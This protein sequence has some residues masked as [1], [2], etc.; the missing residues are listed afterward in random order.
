MQSTSTQKLILLILCWNTIFRA[1]VKHT[2]ALR[3]RQRAG[4]Y[5]KD[6]IGMPFRLCAHVNEFSGYLSVKIS[7][8]INGNEMVSLPCERANVFQVHYFWRISG[9]TDGIGIASRLC[10]HVPV[11]FDSVC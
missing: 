2:V 8:H 7:C 3:V 1:Q 5:Y 11:I 9:Y 4:I 10:S 6:D